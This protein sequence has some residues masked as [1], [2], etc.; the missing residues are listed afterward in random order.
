MPGLHAQKAVVEETESAKDIVMTPHQ[1][2]VERSVS[3]FVM[4]EHSII[5][6]SSPQRNQCMRK[7]S[8]CAMEKNVLVRL[9]FT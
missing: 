2:V 3:H 9:Y 7:L 1:V 6:D 4:K 8:N 5:S